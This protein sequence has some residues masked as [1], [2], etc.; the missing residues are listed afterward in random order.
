MTENTRIWIPIRKSILILI[1]TLIIIVVIA[2]YNVLLVFT[3]LAFSFAYLIYIWRKEEIEREPFMGLIVAFSYGFAN[4]TFLAIILSYFAIELI[5]ISTGD[6]FSIVVV[7]PLV[8]EFSK[9]IGLIIISNYRMLFNEIDDGIIYGASIGLG[10]SAYEN[11]LYAM[12]TNEPI[13]IASLRSICCTAGH[14]ASTAIIG[15]GYAKN[16]FLT[17]TTRL[18]LYFILAILLHVMHNLLAAISPLMIPLI[19][20]IDFTAFIKI[21][22]KVE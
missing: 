13:V 8:E 14:A 17:D 2:F 18:S 7:A 22:S 11:L 15:Y 20:I 16:I 12:G 4:S 10:F 21:L 6:I 19:I 9:F 3:V 5:G 1:L